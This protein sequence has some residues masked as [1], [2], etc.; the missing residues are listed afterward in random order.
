MRTWYDTPERQHRLIAHARLWLGTP[1]LTNGRTRGEAVDCHNLAYALH[2]DTGAHPAYRIPRGRSGIAGQMQV[3][4]MSQFFNTIPF[5]RCIEDGIPL[6]GDILTGMVRGVEAHMIIY[7]GE[8]DGQSQTCITAL[9]GG[10]T[11]IS[12]QDPAWSARLYAIWRTKHED[13]R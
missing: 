10:V 6:P 1:F 3:R 12:L 7:L 8:V 2:Q 4:R 5:M 13:D 11:F 9:R